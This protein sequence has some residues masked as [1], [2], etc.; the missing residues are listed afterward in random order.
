MVYTTCLGMVKL[1][2]Y[3]QGNDLK[4]PSGGYRARPYKVKRKCLGGGP[5]TMTR[6]SNENKIRITRDY[7][8]NHKIRLLEASTA[9]VYVPEENRCVKVK[10]LR[11]LETPANPEYAR[12]GIIVKGAIVDTE[13]GKALVTSRPGQDGVINAILLERR[14][15]EKEKKKK[16]K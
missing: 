4:K 3:Y 1:L 5:P 6:L 8:G 15:E 10:I 14:A 11:V 7:G 16:K 9:N 13:I 12:R 2:S